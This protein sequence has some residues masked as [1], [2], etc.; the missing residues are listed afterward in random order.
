MHAHTCAQN[1][2]T[3]HRQQHRKLCGVG[4]LSREAFVT[5]STIFRV[6]FFVPDSLLL[7]WSMGH[8]LAPEVQSTHS[9]LSLTSAIPQYYSCC[10]SWNSY[11][12]A[13]IMEVPMGSLQSSWDGRMTVLQLN[14][15]HSLLDW[16]LHWE[17][18]G[19]WILERAP[20]TQLPVALIIP[21]SQV[22]DESPEIC[23]FVWTVPALNKRTKCA[24]EHL[25][26][27]RMMKVI[28]KYE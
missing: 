15:W 16:V 3:A 21:W 12:P 25:G 28:N 8:P 7:L 18:F 6:S 22:S 14:T 24:M 23:P 20:L 26:F 10:H 11:L 13:S 1:T 27:S 5:G 4:S 9:P 17:C 2:D 19:F